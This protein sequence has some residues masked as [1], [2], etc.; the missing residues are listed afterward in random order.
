M[1]SSLP[2]NNQQ[3]TGPLWLLRDCTDFRGIGTEGGGGGG[4]PRGSRASVQAYYT[5][6]RL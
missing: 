3:R 6:S 1:P 5:L 2:A 4:G